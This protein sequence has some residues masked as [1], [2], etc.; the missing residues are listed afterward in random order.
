MEVT[1][2]PVPSQERRD[3]VTAAQQ[4]KV[5]L[6]TASL[7]TRPHH[8]VCQESLSVSVPGESLRR[9]ADHGGRAFRQLS[10]QRTG[11]VLDRLLR[12]P[13]WADVRRSASLRGASAHSS[14]LLGPGRPGAGLSV[15]GLQQ[16][17]HQNG[18]FK[19]GGERR[20]VGTSW[21]GWSASSCIYESSHRRSRDGCVAAGLHAQPSRHASELQRNRL[22]SSRT[23]YRKDTGVGTGEYA[24]QY[25]H[26]M[27]LFS[28]LCLKQK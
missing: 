28:F 11:P 7:V 6:I 23:L 3:D 9:E 10:A 12:R 8:T 16:P 24:E 21:F 14:P 25:F 17:G 5:R 27:S 13:A 18:R 26:G 19:H 22:Q 15:P 1:C 20:S 4:E 2:E